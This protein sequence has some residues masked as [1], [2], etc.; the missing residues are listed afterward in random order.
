M[1]K[2]KTI[3]RHLISPKLDLSQSVILCNNCI[4]GFLYHDFSQEFL[5]PTINLQ[6]ESE[7]FL[8][9]CENLEGY[10][11][12]DLKEFKSLEN[13]KLFSEWNTPPFPIAYL[14]D[15]KIYFQHYS[16]FLEAKIAWEKRSARM[17]E[18]IKN[19]A[20]INVIMVR[21]DFGRREYER[22]E[23]LS[24]ENKVYI[25]QFSPEIFVPASLPDTF[26][27]KIPDGKQWFDYSLTP[28]FRY[29]DQFNFKDWLK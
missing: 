24:Y 20:H 10:L 23:K 19:G 18:H 1:N 7:G 13:D 11:R 5:S 21:K 17:L 15:V 22:F 3:C 14:K 27:L 8:K 25:Y 9:L 29:Y 28:F 2:F 6:I 16:S 4:G 12:E 26:A